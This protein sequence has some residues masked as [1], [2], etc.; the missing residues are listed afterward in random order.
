MKRFFSELRLYVCNHVI[1]HLPSHSLRLFY[2][3]RI[4]GFKIGRGSTILMNCSFDSTRNL[5]I[6]QN[7]VINSN[8]RIDTRAKITIG[9]NVSISQ[10]VILLTADHD[11]DSPDF[12][13]RNR[14]VIIGDYVW[15]GTSAL[16]MPNITIG[17][18][19]VVAAGAI[20]TKNVLNYNIVG[21]VPA[22]F[23]RE[24]NRQ[25]KFIYKA[26]YKRLFQ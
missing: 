25:Q 15:I 6:G 9:S 21:G 3:R 8:C 24:R 1:A 22:K 14:E 19:A 10:N 23:L 18:A 5:I 12:G 16:I 17:E 4:M 2:Y 11:M 26:S 13:G 7:S 20:V